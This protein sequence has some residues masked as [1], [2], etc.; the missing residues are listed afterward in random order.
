MGVRHGLQTT[1]HLCNKMESKS[2]NLMLIRE[3]GN[4]VRILAAEA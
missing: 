3:Q 2:L 4:T 1:A